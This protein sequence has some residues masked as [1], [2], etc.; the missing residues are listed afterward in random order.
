MLR[1][2]GNGHSGRPCHAAGVCIGLMLFVNCWIQSP[3]LPPSTGAGPA[4][5]QFPETWKF[6]SSCSLLEFLNLEPEESD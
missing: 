4:F 2:I 5:R 1:K 3:E 6:P